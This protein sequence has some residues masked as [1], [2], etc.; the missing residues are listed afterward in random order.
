MS[1]V[2]AGICDTM[3]DLGRYGY[4]AYGINVAGA[5]DV[6]AMQ[7]ANALVVNELPSAVLEMHFPASVIR[8]NAPALIALSGADFNAIITTSEGDAADFA[9]NKTAFVTANSLLS[10][11]KKIKGERCYLAVHGG[12]VLQPWLNSYS[13][14]LKIQTGGFNGRCLKK[15]DTIEFKKSSKLPGNS[16]KRFPWTANF[17]SWYGDAGSY[18]FIA[19][20]EF[21]W[22]DVAS[23]KQFMRGLFT[24]GQHSDRMGITLTGNLLHQAN[25]EQLISSGVTYGT[26]QL[27]PNGNL[28]VLAADRPTTGGYPRIGN[29]IQAHLPKLAQASAGATIRFLQTNI[30]SAS[31]LLFLQQNELKQMQQAVRLILQHLL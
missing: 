10:F 31:Q 29:I 25:N 9:V 11:P 4:G 1:I 5:M 27:L 20:P 8:F 16:V 12:F 24:I 23:Q 19:G 3:Q 14:N 26:M 2:K 13:T 7:T 17:Y 30:E 18:N 6:L 21:N 15:D 28:V 22:L